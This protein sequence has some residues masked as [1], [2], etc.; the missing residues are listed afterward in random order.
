MTRRLK[1]SRYFTTKFSNWL[2]EQ[3]ELDSKKGYT[4]SDLD[5]IWTSYKNN[6]FIM[7]EEKCKM[8]EIGFAQG[9]IL[10]R[11]HSLFKADNDYCGFYFLQWEF[12]GPED[13]AIYITNMEEGNKIEIDKNQLTKFLIDFTMPQVA[14]FWSSF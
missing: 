8:S 2:R 9:K 13:G 4:C 11:M 14:D 1:D 3:P 5:M 10:N 6:K 12:E 7:L